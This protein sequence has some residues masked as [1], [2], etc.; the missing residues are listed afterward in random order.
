[1]EEGWTRLACAVINRAVKD[2][3]NGGDGREGA[4]ELRLPRGVT[5]AMDAR[6][7]LESQAA[8]WLWG[9]LGLDPDYLDRLRAELKEA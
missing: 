9:L 3:R 5:L 8:E 4:R 6:A 2:A 1:M 7:F